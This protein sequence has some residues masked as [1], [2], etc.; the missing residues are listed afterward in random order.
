M[1]KGNVQTEMGKISNLITDMTLKGASTDELARA[2][3][4]SMVVIDAYK[5]KLD[6]TQSYKDN[7]I[8]DLKKLYQKKP[9]GTYGGASTLLSRAK[10]EVYIPERKK[11]AMVVDPETG[12]EVRR[13]ID[14]V[15]GEKL[16]S[17]TNRMRKD[18][19]LDKD[20]KPILTP[21]GKKQ[22]VE[23]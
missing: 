17:N 21:D 2:V 10:S 15:T 6:Y 7:E 9:D 23:T 20:K 5:H 12:K 8:E 4:H 14:P 11:G 19:L 13:Y 3:R 22:Y 16:Y 18:L 1:E